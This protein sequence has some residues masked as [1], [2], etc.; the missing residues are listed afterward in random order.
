MACGGDDTEPSAGIP[1]E[2]HRLL[3]DD[4]AKTW[5][6]LAPHL[7]ASLY[8]GGGTGVAV[9]LRHRESR[10]LDFFS[11]QDVDL[12]CLRQTLEK[13]GPFAAT[14]EDERTLKGLYG[15]TKLEIF[16]VPSIKQLAASKVVAGLRIGDLRDLMAMKIKVLAER[17]E[18][19]DYFDVRTIDEIGGISVEEGIELYLERYDVDPSSGALRHLY[20]AM[21]D[22]SD[23]EEDAA[24]PTTTTEL[25]AWWSKRQL[26]VIRNS[27]RFS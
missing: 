17:G 18:A 2:V 9:H 12:E 21:G 20:L 27:D 10:D 1:P 5:V 25:Q 22:L 3:P 14:F 15:R 11:H 6:E 23:V 13:L 24:L 16:V 7:P 8:L 4:T 26:R 19:R